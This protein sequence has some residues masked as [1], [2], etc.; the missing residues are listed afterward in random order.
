MPLTSNCHQTCLLYII[1]ITVRENRI[2]CCQIFSDLLLKSA[3]EQIFNVMQLILVKIKWHIKVALYKD[4]FPQQ[5]I[6]FSSTVMQMIWAWHK[7][8]T[9]SGRLSLMRNVQLMKKIYIYSVCTMHVSSRNMFP[10]TRNLQICV[11]VY[12]PRHYCGDWLTKNSSHDMK[13][14]D[15]SII[16]VRNVCVLTSASMIV[17]LFFTRSWLAIIGTKQPKINQS[18]Q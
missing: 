6:L 16:I 14:T 1:Y 15:S 17:Y 3:F 5:I 13:E 8:L 12:R 4:I 7:I 10:T 2:I 18:P 11:H 9:L